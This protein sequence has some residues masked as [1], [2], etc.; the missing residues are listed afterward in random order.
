MTILATHGDS[1]VHEPQ[2][3]NKRHVALALANFFPLLPPRAASAS[4]DM[5]HGLYRSIVGLA[6]GTGA[7]L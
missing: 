1:A 2:D 6:C 7:H 4:D 5:T 3:K